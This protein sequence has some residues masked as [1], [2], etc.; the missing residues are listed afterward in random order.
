[1]IV[2][3]FLGW[4]INKG[5][6][7][8]C[9]IND[10]LQNIH[11]LQVMIR[12]LWISRY[13]VITRDA[14]FAV[15]STVAFGTALTNPLIITGGGEGV[16]ARWSWAHARLTISCKEKGL[17]SEMRHKQKHRKHAMHRCEFIFFLAQI[18]RMTGWQ[19]S[20]L[21]EGVHW[22]ISPLLLPNQPPVRPG[23]FPYSSSRLGVL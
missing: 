7:E 15:R 21:E 3:D 20:Y 22:E 12:Y 16:Q 14:K 23:K 17:T 4:Q 6:T 2:L 10:D 8:K 5:V 11:R 9:L 18:T 1:M 19:W 13:A